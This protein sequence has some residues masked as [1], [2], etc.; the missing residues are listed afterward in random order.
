MRF[1]IATKLF[2]YLFV[3]ESAS[4]TRRFGGPAK[5]AGQ[6]I[7]VQQFPGCSLRGTTSGRA[8]FPRKFTI[9][10]EMHM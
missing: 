3:G 8:S 7:G 6:W 5:E 1:Q 2:N 9:I 10:F 4:E